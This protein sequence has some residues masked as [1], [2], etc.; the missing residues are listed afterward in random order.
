MKK[1]FYLL[2][3][4]F[5]IVNISCKKDKDNLEAEDDKLS[6]LLK[7]E[8]LATEPND[9]EKKFI[10]SFSKDEKCELISLDDTQ[11]PIDTLVGEFS[12]D[13]KI[14]VIGFKFTGN[15]NNLSQLFA[16]KIKSST[17]LTLTQYNYVAKVQ[18]DN[19][20]GPL[21]IELRKITKGSL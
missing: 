9:P 14:N 17:E 5:S 19:T 21:I 3:I 16:T 15:P 7:D 4:S 10:L 8:W 13:D 1:L 12:V 11:K 18:S 2:L 6:S 20:I